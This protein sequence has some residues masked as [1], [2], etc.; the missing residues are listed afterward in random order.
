MADIDMIPRE[1]RDGVRVRR[2]LRL[3][4]IALALVVAAGALA[5]IGLRW[6]TAALERSATAL[7]AAATQ[8]QADSAR[9]AEQQAARS[10]QEQVHAVL[11]TLRRQGE[12]AALAHSLDAVPGDAV[13]LTG[14]RIERDVQGVSPGANAAATA[15]ALP[16]GTETFSAP[17]A[18]PAAPVQIWHLRS[19][20]E[21][22][23]QAAS[24]EAV[25]AFLSALGRQPGIAGLRLV[26]SSVAEGGAIDF[27][28]TG[29]LIHQGTTP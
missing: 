23:G 11:R 14:L 22:D 2:T 13:W 16:D 4:G 9:G 24:Y 7:E 5:G 6:R 10:R 15:P 12:L 21:L 18:T 20:I 19:A 28:A 8:A 1:Y 29:A 3:A 25:T 26:S 17:G 27:H